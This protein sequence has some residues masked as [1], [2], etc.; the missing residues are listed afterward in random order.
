MAK[1][2]YLCHLSS[3][4]NSIIYDPTTFWWF[5]KS[6]KFKELPNYTHL[7]EISSGDGVQVVN[8]FTQ[9]FSIVYVSFKII[10][11]TSGVYNFLFYLYSTL[12][13]SL[14]S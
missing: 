3:I 9:H 10:N 7:N 11:L 6:K 8:L 12:N 13:L 5:I 14:S 4:H 1:R 2:D